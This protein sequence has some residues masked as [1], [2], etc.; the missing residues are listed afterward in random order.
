MSGPAFAALGAVGGAFITA[1]A[2]VVVFMVQRRSVLRN[3]HLLRAFEK[4]LS[5]VTG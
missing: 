3:E 2:S 5:D 4:H 1:V